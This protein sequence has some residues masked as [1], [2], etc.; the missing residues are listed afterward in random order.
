MKK[1]FVF[2]V[3]LLTGCSSAQKTMESLPYYEPTNEEQK[4]QHTMQHIRTADMAI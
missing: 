2:L 3:L 1:M 4:L